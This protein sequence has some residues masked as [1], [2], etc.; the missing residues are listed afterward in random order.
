[1]YDLVLLPNEKQLEAL[2]DMMRHAFVEIRALCWAGHTE[3]AGDLADAFHNLPHE[4]YGRGRW[5]VG[6]FRQML[7]SYQDRHGAVGTGVYNYVGMLDRIFP[8]G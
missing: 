6:T 8:G 3:R 5:D 4:M 1:M 7:Q 2:C